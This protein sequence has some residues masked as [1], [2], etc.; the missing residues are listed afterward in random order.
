MIT[1]IPLTPN[2][3]QTVSISEVYVFLKKLNL[4]YVDFGDWFWGTM[5]VGLQLGSRKI[6]VLTDKDCLVGVSIL[7]SNY[8]EQ[9]ICTFRI[10]K[11]YQSLGLGTLLM[12]ESLDFFPKHLPILITMCENKEA[13]FKP[14]LNKF[15]FRYVKRMAKPNGYE[16]YYETKK[17]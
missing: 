9:K 2:S 5:Y 7:K 1:V 16:V 6:I 8:Y 17:V 11:K 12:R 15:G 10:A 13:K 14:L 3:K 4:D